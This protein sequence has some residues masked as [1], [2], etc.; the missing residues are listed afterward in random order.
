MQ[1][2]SVISEK[3]L[4]LVVLVLAFA[5]QFGVLLRFSH[6]TDFVPQ[7]DDMKFYSDWGLRIAHGQWTDG[8]AF[9]GLPGYAYI[10][11]GFYRVLGLDPFTI[12]FVQ[13][14][15]FALVAFVI[16]RLALLVFPASESAEA[17]ADP[18]VPGV[19]AALGWTFFVPAQT[20]AT[21]LMPTVWLVL[22][23]WA[24]VAW[25][26]R[27]REASI[28]RPWLAMGLAVGVMSMVVATIL[29]AVPLIVFA[30]WRTVAAGS[31]WKSRAPRLAAAV[32]VFV[33]GVFAGSSPASLHNHLVAHEPVMLSAHSGIN[34]WIGNNP[35]ATGYPKMP[36]GIRAS[37]DGL[38]RDSITLAETAAGRH[39]TRAEVS[40][41][42]AKQADAYIHAHFTDWLRL[43]G[44]KF[45]NFW[46]AY[47]YDDIST[48]KLLRDEGV[49]WPGLRFGFVAALGLAGMLFA[50]RAAPRS[51]WVAAAV[52]LHMCALMPVFV[53]ERY[54]LAAVPGLLLFAAWWAATLQARLVRGKWR[55]ALP[56]FACAIPAALFVSIPRADA[57]LWSL[58]YYKT[59]IRA[60]ESG[61]L[62]RA[63]R[64]LEMAEKYSPRSADIQFALGNLRL[65]KGEREAAKSHFRHALELDPRHDG[66]LNNLGVMALE[67]GRPEL[68][69]KF[70][71]AGL[72]VEPLDAKRYYLLARA[73]FDRHDLVGAREAITTA[74]RLKPGQPEFLEFQSKLTAP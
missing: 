58:D 70:I 66:V 56:L 11:G 15:L 45:V 30:M 63:G 54:R 41:F 36:P 49:T 1:I 24:I 26:V 37:Q 21:V 61:D 25:V 52:L 10:L 34:F 8:K 14:G 62:Q 53:T 57:T 50:F 43:M 69:E 47:Q 64:D 27:T 32:A 71:A 60:I 7:G 18:R 39:L 74:L 4:G 38:L 31:A 28:V 46:N 19:L 65:G 48:M 12:G 20:F 35:T 23:Y 6:S 9:Y 3:R 73:R 2:S 51:R 29:F 40:V 13:A 44:R 72:E 22:A 55:A 16:Y 67:E 17:V 59:G 33:A 42:W 5:V 68:A